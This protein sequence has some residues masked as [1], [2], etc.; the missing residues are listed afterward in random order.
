MY[1]PADKMIENLGNL[2]NNI[3]ELPKDKLNKETTNPLFESLK[4]ICEVY[5]SLKADEEKNI[6]EHLNK[7]L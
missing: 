7:Y 3:I 5:L 6:L 4:F 2:V 1:Y